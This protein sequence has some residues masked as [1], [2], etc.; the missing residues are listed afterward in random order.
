LE[1]LIAY[2]QW[3][4][5]PPIRGISPRVEVLFLLYSV[6]RESELMR[7]MFVVSPSKGIY[8]G[9]DEGN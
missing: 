2:N 5:A 6:M 7:K 3:T 4:E 8:N 1:Y 9:L